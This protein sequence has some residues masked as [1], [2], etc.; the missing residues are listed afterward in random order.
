MADDK[1]EQMKQ[2]Y[3]SVLNVIQ[4][5]QV[6]LSHLHIQDGKLFMQGVAPSEQAKNK[7][8]DQIKLVN[9]KYDDITADLTVDTSAQPQP[10]Q[11]QPAGN[12]RKVYTVQPGDS[13]SIIAKRVYGDANQYMKI[14]EANR[15][16]LQDPNKIYPGQQLTIP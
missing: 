6:R 11:T 10:A 15:D 5:Q 4:Q 16:K 3:A 1:L 8:W 12:G 9:P 13:L 14:F 2:K 7:V